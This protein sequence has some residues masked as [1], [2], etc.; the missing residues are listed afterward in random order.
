MCGI[1]AY[2]LGGFTTVTDGDTDTLIHTRANIEKNRGIGE[3]LGSI[4]C[5]QLI[6]GDDG[7]DQF[8]RR[9]RSGSAAGPY[10]I[11][12]G[13]DIIYLEEVLEPLF[14]TIKSLLS[15]DGAVW[16]AYARRN[17]SIDLVLSRATRHGFACEAPPDAE[18][19][20]VFRRCPI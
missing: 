6:W 14:S 11:I 3:A 17:V 12:L 2:K 1:L 20:F 18:G 10:D 19:V 4:E 8:R 15:S 5:Q 13:S 9:S 16:L 7:V